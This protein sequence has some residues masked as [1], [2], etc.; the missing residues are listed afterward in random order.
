MDGDH[1]TTVAI[2][3]ALK[4]IRRKYPVLY[5]LYCAKLCDNRISL[6]SERLYPFSA[7]PTLGPTENAPALSCVRQGSNRSAPTVRMLEALHAPM[8]TLTAVSLSIPATVRRPFTA[9]T[10][11]PTPLILRD[12]VLA[13]AP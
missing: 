6:R 9:A 3:L 5:A 8:F 7:V 4:G 1:V 12:L 13:S 11:S 2:A 10:A